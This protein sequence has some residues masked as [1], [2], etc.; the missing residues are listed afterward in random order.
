MKK[1]IFDLDDV[2]ALN[3]FL[4][5][6]NNFS[7]TNYKYEDIKGYYVE[8]LLSNEELKKY[9]KFFKENN[10]Y[11]YATIDPY[12]Y[13][14]LMNIMLEYELYICSSYVDMNGIILP[15]LIVKKCEFLNKNFPFLTQKN[16]IF[17]NDKTMLEADLK[18]DDKIE[19]LTGNGIKILFTTYYNKN[20]D[21]LELELKGIVRVNNPIEIEKIALKKKVFTNK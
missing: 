21:D 18:V 14:L 3:G 8:S 20:I 6:L 5:M 19:N 15:H 11:D 1:A 16:F 10:V 2:I 12:M 4:N 13:K 9:E 7:K 17:T